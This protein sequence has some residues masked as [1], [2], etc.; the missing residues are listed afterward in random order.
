MSN[1]ENEHSE[2]ARAFIA[3]YGRDLYLNQVK[4]QR[5]QRA[6]EQAQREAEEKE[7]RR[8]LESKD[9]NFLKQ[10]IEQTEQKLD[11]ADSLVDDLEKLGESF[12]QDVEE[13]TIKLSTEVGLDLEKKW[14]KAY[15]E[16]VAETQ[17]KAE[18]FREGLINRLVEHLKTC[19]PIINTVLN[20]AHLMES[21]PKDNIIWRLTLYRMEDRIHIIEENMTKEP[22]KEDGE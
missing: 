19:G 21:E 7:R 15:A 9:T 20:I 13:S 1:F 22:D 2:E 12:K 14:Q 16:A 8:E 17:K 5:E 11:E 10:V 3:K 6:R 4:I 18:E